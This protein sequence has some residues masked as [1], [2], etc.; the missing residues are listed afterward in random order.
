MLK[1]ICEFISFGQNY[2]AASLVYLGLTLIICV[3]LPMSSHVR[4]QTNGCPEA[5]CSS[6]QKCCHGI[7]IPDSYICCEDGSNGPSANSYGECGCCR[8]CNPDMCTNV[9][10]SYHCASENN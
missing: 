3:T 8:N 6:G 9:L 4:A 1:K 10:S 7:C 2:F 5:S